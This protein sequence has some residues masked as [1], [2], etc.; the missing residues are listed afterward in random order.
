[1]SAHHEAVQRAFE[2]L[3]VE[4]RAHA[5]RKPTIAAVAARAG[6]SRSSMYRFHPGI[7]AQIRSLTGD[8]DARKQDQLRVKAQLLATQLKSERQFI[9]ALARACAELAAEKAALQEQFE[10]ERLSLQLK[11]AHLE[12]QLQGRRNVTI[13]R[14]Q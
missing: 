6:I 4:S 11:V 5:E 10:N 2:S 9:R 1:M 8:R 7:V 13:L 12:K 14:R 3:L